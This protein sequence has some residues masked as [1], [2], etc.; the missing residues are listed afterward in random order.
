MSKQERMYTE[1]EVAM[2]NIHLL[3]T[4]KPSRLRYNLSNVL[5]LTEESYRDYGKLDNQHIYITSDEKIKKSDFFYVKTPNIHGGN[6]VTKCLNI[7]K[8]CWSEHIL[9]DTIDEKGYH[10][11]HCKK[12]ILTT[13]QDLIAEGVQAIDDEFLEWFVKNPGCE[14]VEVKKGKMKVNDDGCRYGFPDM[15]LYE[16][17]IPQEEPKQETLEDACDRV[18]NYLYPNCKKEMSSLQY[19]NSINSLK[20]IAKWQQEQ[21][22]K[23]YSEEEVEAIW[24][25][26]LYSAEQHDKFGTKN[27]SNF[28]TKDVKEFIE[29]FKKK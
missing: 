25:F 19:G 14:F 24:K 4:E 9:T 6:I 3:P 13:D 1:E 18:L 26:A 29:Q 27:K 21:D 8:G 11:S 20:Y 15:S 22:K 7:G 23:L 12:I 5:V 2:K 16:I 28:I 17:I 10:P